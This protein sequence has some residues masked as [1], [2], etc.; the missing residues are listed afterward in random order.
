L[1]KAGIA[2]SLIGEIFD[3]QTTITECVDEGLKELGESAI[4]V[5]YFHLEKN[6]GIRKNEI[7]VKPM[8][9]SQAL[10]SIF[11]QG[12]NV[13]ERLIVQ[14]IEEKFKLRLD[15]QTG[16]AEA[17]QAVKKGYKQQLN[18][19][20]Y[21]VRDDQMRRPYPKSRSAKRCVEMEVDNHEALMVFVVKGV[22]C[23]QPS[24]LSSRSPL[25]LRQKRNLPQRLM[26]A[27]SSFDLSK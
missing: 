8:A 26:T 19:K 18:T 7:P 9:F 11:G 22:F 25:L 14:K 20:V 17:I 5:V 1:G 10:H 21:D 27:F 12:A 6:F 15:P 13:I 16:L 2:V 23:R 3:F 4:K 24:R